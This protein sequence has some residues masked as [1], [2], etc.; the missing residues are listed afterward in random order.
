MKRNKIIKRESG[1][2]SSERYSLL[3]SIQITLKMTKFSF[4]LIKIRIKGNARKMFLFH[5]TIKVQVAYP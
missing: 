5:L 4:D 1:M 3:K 2:N